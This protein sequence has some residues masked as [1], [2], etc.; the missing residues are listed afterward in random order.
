MTEFIESWIT[1]RFSFRDVFFSPQS[2]SYDFI[3]VQIIGPREYKMENEEL[4]TGKRL[5]SH[6]KLELHKC[7]RLSEIMGSSIV[8]HRV[9]ATS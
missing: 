6:N 3:L 2:S 9:E 8:R 5:R 7:G 1:T 4:V